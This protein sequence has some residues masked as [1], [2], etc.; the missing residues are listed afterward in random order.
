[1]QVQG[2][3]LCNFNPTFRFWTSTNLSS[4][5]ANG[6]LIWLGFQDEG[7]AVQEACRASFAGAGSPVVARCSVVISSARSCK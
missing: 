1:V 6:S 4:A 5:M 3:F 7:D 2:A